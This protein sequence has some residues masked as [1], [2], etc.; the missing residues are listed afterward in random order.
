MVA[1]EVAFV[2]DAVERVAEPLCVQLPDYV[3]NKCPSVNSAAAVSTKQHRALTDWVAD[4][5]NADL[6]VKN[7]IRQVLIDTA[8]G[9]ALPSDFQGL[10]SDLDAAE[11]LE[12][13]AVAIQGLS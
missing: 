2:T 8:A 6:Q 1:E 4:V 5:C 7:L 13:L 10:C 12:V 9:G 11:V 3:H